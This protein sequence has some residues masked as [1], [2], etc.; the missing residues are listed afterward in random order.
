[1]SKQSIAKE[2]Q[3]YVAKPTWPVCGNC[4]SYASEFVTEPPAFGFG[5][6]ARE[7]NVRCTIGGF[8]VGK[9]GTCKRH[10]EKERNKQ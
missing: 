1:M 6:W 4:A 7:I 9:S 5:E 8:K 3:G 10:A 2:N